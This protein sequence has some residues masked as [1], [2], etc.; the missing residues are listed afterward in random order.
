M[1][2]FQTCL[3][4]LSAFVQADAALIGFGAIFVIYKLQSLDS[5]RQ[6]LV[7]SYY[8]KGNVHTG[9]MNT[10][11][12]STNSAD[13]AKVLL[14]IKPNEQDFRNYVHVILIPI[15]SQRLRASVKLPMIAVALHIVASSV[16]L[17]TVQHFYAT[18]CLTTWL[19]WLDLAW[20]AW[21]IFLASRLAL[22]MLTS[23]DNYDL[24]AMLPDVNRLVQA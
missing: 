21:I 2:L 24:E 23:S 3:Y 4:F 12:L 15:Y 9:N 1:E 5:L 14:G 20:F 17:L 18:T 6:S 7:Q 22:K 8:T 16:L 10:L 19:M 11:L 13:L